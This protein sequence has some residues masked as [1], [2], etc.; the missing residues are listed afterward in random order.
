MSKGRLA[1][2][3]VLMLSI[4]GL[5]ASP[6]R[7]DSDP[8][9]VFGF[10]S[11][12]FDDNI[13]PHL[14]LLGRL[15]GAEVQRIAV[16]WIDVQ[17]KGPNQS[18]WDQYDQII[19]DTLDA[20]VQPLLM[21]ADAPEWADDSS[22]DAKHCPPGKG[23]YDDWATWVGEV[24]SRYPEIWGI[25][26][27]N[28]PNTKAWWN[29]DGGPSPPRYAEVFKWAARVIHSLRPGMPVLFP[30]IG[31]SWRGD[32]TGIVSIPTFLKKFYNT[33]GTFRPNP[34]ARTDMLSF[35]PYPA[36]S[37]L[38]T[39]D[40]Q[41]ARAKQ[42]VREKRNARDPGRQLFV[43]EVGISTTGKGAPNEPTQARG[44]LRIVRDLENDHDM[45]G[46]IVHTLYE[47]KGNRLYPIEKGY[48][49]VERDTFRPKPAFCVLARH[50]GTS[51]ETLEAF[52]IPCSEW[53]YNLDYQ[54]SGSSTD[55][56]TPKSS[57]RS[58]KKQRK[59]RC[60]GLFCLFR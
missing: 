32:R 48:G 24:T 9:S 10:T 28:A 23:H 3:L 30:S 25:E 36:K 15:A 42:Q 52:R 54:K 13:S 7:A 59:R 19:Q 16:R 5:A 60:R 39:L 4:L 18:T 56:T 21:L 17:R 49:V 51:K 22:C 33:I 50:A 35:H 2:A 27:W 29:V 11:S 1:G 38:D 6:A 20:G 58:T 37:E 41:Y 55:T 8:D 34:L 45:R 14:S 26:I 47:T 46:I 40:G 43:T 44:L 53:A 12:P 57:G 31:Y